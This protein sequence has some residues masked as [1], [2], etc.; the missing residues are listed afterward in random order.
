MYESIFQ[1]GRLN[2]EITIEPPLYALMEFDGFG[3]SNQTES[4][5]TSINEQHKSNE[6]NTTIFHGLNFCLIFLI[7][8][9]GT[10]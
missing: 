5:P 10:C 3:A 8:F 6:R 7:S 9:A 2:D 4:V 1:P